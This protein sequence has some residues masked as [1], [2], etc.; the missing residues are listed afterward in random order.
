MVREQ[1][2]EGQPC[3]RKRPPKSYKSYFTGHR[4][5]FRVIFALTD[6]VTSSA[7][8]GQAWTPVPEMEDLHGVCERIG[9]SL[10]R[11]DCD[12]I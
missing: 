6:L 3:P 10:R 12:T 1:H 8:S 5:S 7:E 11:V 2:V 4:E 9:A